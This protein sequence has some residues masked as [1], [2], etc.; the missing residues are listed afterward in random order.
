[1]EDA[2]SVH[3]VH[4]AHQLVHVVL[5]AVLSY[6]VPP[7]PDELVDVHVHELKHKGQPSSGLVVQH[8][9]H[10][11]EGMEGEREGE[12]HLTQ[13]DYCAPYHACREYH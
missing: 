10:R 11:T 4:R 8:L 12:R 2:I 5:D 7:A 13:R 9:E 3:V 6:I 1:M